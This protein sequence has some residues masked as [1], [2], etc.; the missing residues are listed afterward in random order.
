M[1][2]FAIDLLLDPFSYIFA[3]L[4]VALFLSFLRLIKG[5]SLPDRVVALD[6]ITLE[7]IGL[8]GVFMVSTDQPAFLDAAIALAIVAFV[9]T[10]AFARYL[11]QRQQDE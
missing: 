2:K 5:P 10:V 11:E 3:M 1:T 6:L 4:V 7:I 8:I 9:G